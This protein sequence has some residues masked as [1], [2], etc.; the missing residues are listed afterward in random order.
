MSKLNVPTEHNGIKLTTVT[1][2]I[3]VDASA[4]AIWDA[5]SHFGDVA[6]FHSGV[7]TSTP[8]EGFSDVAALGTERICKVPDGKREVTLVERITD[9]S[10][11]EYYR[12]EVYEWKNFPL[13]AMFFA[14]EIVEKGSG[15]RVLQ[16]SQ[17][18]RLK[19]GFLTRPMKYKIRQQ[20]RTILL[21]YKHYIE[22]GEK[23]VATSDIAGEV[24][25]LTS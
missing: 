17:H 20:Q 5:L 1:S 22:T 3:A 16:L 4:E 21:G 14:F 15:K 11:G 13:Q 2:E 6:S 18:Y 8:T 10:E 19:P 7:R 23:N 24:L 9:F 25:V 12:Y